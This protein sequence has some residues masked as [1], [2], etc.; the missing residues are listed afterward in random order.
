MAKP[1]EGE[2]DETRHTVALPALSES[3]RAY[4]HSS[5]WLALNV[6]LFRYFRSVNKEVANMKVISQ[7]IVAA[8]ASKGWSAAGAFLSFRSYVRNNRMKLFG[9]CTKRVAIAHH[10]C[11]GVDLHLL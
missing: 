6:L 3:V 4:V 7:K 9:R 5:Y 1:K 11:A 10:R 2:R 8:N